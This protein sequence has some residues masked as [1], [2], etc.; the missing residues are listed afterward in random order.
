L[1]DG[2]IGVVFLL[3]KGLTYRKRKAWMYVYSKKNH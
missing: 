2:L 1:I 3:E